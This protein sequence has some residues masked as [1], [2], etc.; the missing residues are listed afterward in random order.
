MSAVQIQY[1]LNSWH[2]KG[3]TGHYHLCTG[4]NE[5]N[6]GLY[7]GYALKALFVL[8]RILSSLKVSL[9][10]IGHNELC[11]PDYDTKGTTKSIQGIL[12]S[13]RVL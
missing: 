6:P 12:S 8:H 2:Y 10:C 1:M 5:L 13:I 4:H 9:I 7:R 11:V 3:Y